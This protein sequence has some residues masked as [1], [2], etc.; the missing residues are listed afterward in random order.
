MVLIFLQNDG[1]LET[2]RPD[3]THAVEFGSSGN[4]DK[5]AELK[6]VVNRPDA[7]LSRFFKVLRTAG[8][9]IGGSPAS[10]IALLK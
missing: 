8:L 7:D 2:E 1:A 3:T 9:V 6:S 4:C 5:A 10:M